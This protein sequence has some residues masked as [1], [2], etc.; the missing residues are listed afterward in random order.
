MKNMVNGFFYVAFLCV[1]IQQTEAQLPTP[2]AGKVWVKVAGMSDE[3]DAQS[4]DLEKWRV[5]DHGDSWDRTS[6]FDKRINEAVKE[7]GSDNYF[8][9]MNPMWYY[10]DEQFTKGDRT[11]LFAGGGMDT[12]EMATY[13][14]FEVRVKPSNFPMGSGVFMNSRKPSSDI[15]EEKYNTELDICENMSYDGPG[16]NTTGFN[17]HMNVNSHAKP[18]TLQDGSCVTLPFESENSGV[19]GK[20]LEG[21]LDF[22]VVGMWWKNENQAEFFLNGKS[23]GTITPKRDFNLPM[24]VIIVM[25]TYTWGDDENNAGNPKPLE[26]MFEDEFRTKDQR[27]VTYDWVR[28]WQLV[29]IDATRFNGSNYELEFLENSD[30]I[31]LS[32]IISRSLVYSAEAASEIVITVQDAGGNSL[33]T[34]NYT[35]AAGVNSVNVEIDLSRELAIQEVCTVKAILISGEEN[36][37]TDLYTF[38]VETKQVENR[39]FSDLMPTRL[40]P[41][42]SSYAVKIRYEADGPMEISGEIR[43]PANNW[44]GGATSQPVSGEGFVTLNMPVN[45]TTTPQAGYYFKA[46]IRPVGTGWQDAVHA[47]Q[48]FPFT[49]ADPVTPGINITEANVVLQEGKPVVNVAF[50]YGTE[51]DVTLE[52]T[53]MN[54][55]FEVKASKSR[56]ERVGERSLIRS[57]FADS[58]LTG[59]SDY[60]VIVKMQESSGANIYADTL[61]NLTIETQQNI[62]EISSSIK[63]HIFPNPAIDELNILLSRSDFSEEIELKV[64][65]ISGRHIQVPGSIDSEEFT[66]QVDVSTLPKGIYTA[67]IKTRETSYSSRFI[68]Q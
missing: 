8:L 62:L 42:S 7:D 22:N 23:F 21:P 3:F 53:L 48:N 1:L 63:P 60:K 6:A 39:V 65:D 45:T 26:Y 33:G 67:Q 2:P 59:A 68:K 51:E 12:R 36:L 37:A 27:A 66:M 30:P 44:L 57:I 64:Y 49:V 47:I 56:I 50:D 61:H 25:E 38:T 5:F 52:L 11:Y 29:D 10:E 14:Y 4:P 41:T 55:E 24:P 31:Y 43:D 32:S 9:T 18:Y 28:T 54:S 40:P 16:A 58:I 35:I 13:G 19:N 46:H 34:E 17:N 20:P 15:C